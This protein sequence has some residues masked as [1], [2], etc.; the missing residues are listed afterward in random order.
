M[1]EDMELNTAPGDTAEVWTPVHAWRA[2]AKIEPIAA[3]DAM[4]AI[5]KAVDEETDSDQP[6]VDLVYLCERIGAPALPSLLRYLAD[7][8]MGQSRMVAADC[9]G[10][11][12]EL[13]S[14]Q[15]DACVGILTRQL[16]RFDENED[17]LNAMIICALIHNGA[18]EAAPQIERAF[19]AGKV[20]ER[21][22]G[23]WETV[24]VD[25]GLIERPANWRRSMFR[26]PAI[27]F[28]E[29]PMNHAAHANL[30]AKRKAQRQAKKKNRKNR[31]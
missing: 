29:P 5:N 27:V 23:D 25:M 31:R 21:I 4:L 19:A 15:R 12:G 16:E 6:R 30:R 22:V 14:E 17:A 13:H 9:I 20:D 24:Q 18:E 26:S 8:T 28:V 11:I 1:I 10:R 2:L 7:A 3:L